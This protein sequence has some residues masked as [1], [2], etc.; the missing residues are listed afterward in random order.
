MKSLP[1][2]PIRRAFVFL[3]ACWFALV[4]GGCKRTP[5]E[6][7]NLDTE[8]LQSVEKGDLASSKK[9]L[10]KG[11]NI[12]AKD[13]NGSTPLLLAVDRGDASIVKFLLDRGARLDVRDSSYANALMGSARMD[14]TAIL[15]ALL[16]RSAD[17]NAMKE[18]LFF[19]IEE[20]PM[21][22]PMDEKGNIIQNFVPPVPL[23]VK[24]L[25]D[26]GVEINAR[27]EEGTTLLM[28]AA[29]FGQLG[30]AK[31]LLERGADLEARDNNGNTALLDAACDCA[32][33]TMPDTFD[34]M[35]FLLER[36]ADVNV[37]NK[38]GNTPLLIAS[39]GGVVKTDIVRL[40]LEHGANQR[41]KNAHGET[42]IGI[43]QKDKVTD[44]VRLLKNPPVKSH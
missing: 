27:D 34:V 20:Q 12:E 22:I 26:R 2:S 14:H 42:A 8:L 25:L 44:V 18:A 19:T 39:G 28:A 33:A 4:C 13:V 5:A 32:V 1:R 15:E 35:K 23:T 41:L 36:G 16:Q 43:A 17:P 37:T 31:F 21:G 10:K 40:L 9:L 24:L 7:Q 3:L 6:Q 29:G 11:A 30:I 38:E